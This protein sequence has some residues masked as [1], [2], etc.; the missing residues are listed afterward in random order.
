MGGGQLPSESEQ[1]LWSRALIEGVLSS[2]R[3]HPLKYCCVPARW[4][5]QQTTRALDSDKTRGQVS[6]GPFTGGLNLTPTGEPPTC[7]VKQRLRSI[8]RLM[9]S[10]QAFVPNGLTHVKH[11]NI[12]DLDWMA[13]NY[14][15]LGDIRENL[16]S[17]TKYR[18]LIT[19]CWVGRPIYW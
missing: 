17:Q 15:H 12:T 3:F 13:A 11:L 18:R 8:L 4:G 16:K 10:N 14:L 6:F 19:T 9:R 1:A 2:L 7:G 5:L